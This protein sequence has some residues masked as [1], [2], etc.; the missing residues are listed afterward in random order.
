MKLPFSTAT[1]MRSLSLAAATS[2]AS[3]STRSEIFSALN[4]G[5]M[6]SA[7]A[8]SAMILV[9]LG[10]THLDTADITRRRGNLPEERCVLA[11]RKLLLADLGGPLRDF[12][13][14]LVTKRDHDYRHVDG[15]RAGIDHV[16]LHLEHGL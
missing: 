8:V 15:G 6:S 13:A 3:S 5:L 2:R 14:A 11:G 4:S 16:A 1:M 12:I 10:E 7:A 9:G